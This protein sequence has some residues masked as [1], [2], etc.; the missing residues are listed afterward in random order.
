MKI[1]FLYGGQGSQK[2]GM[3]KD[4]YDQY[5]IFKDFYDS[6]STDFDLKDYSFNQSDEEISKTVYATIDGSI[7]NWNNKD[8]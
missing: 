2:K 1:C 6:L 7:S 5:S 8:T 4:L 3:G